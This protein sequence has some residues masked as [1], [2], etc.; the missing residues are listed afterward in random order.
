MPVPD[1]FASCVLN[2]PIHVATEGLI[3]SN[4]FAVATDGFIIRSEPGSGIGKPNVPPGNIGALITDPR[5]EWYVRE[6]K[7]DPLDGPFTFQ[8]ANARAREL[9]EDEDKSGLSQ[10][11]TFVGSDSRGGDPVKDPSEL[12]VV[13]MYIRGNRTLGGRTATYHSDRELPPTV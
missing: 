4:V 7:N 8:I 5:Q 2:V 1:A 9:S 6:D 11:V 3:S 12:H 13:F 10:I